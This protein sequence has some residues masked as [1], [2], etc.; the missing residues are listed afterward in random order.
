[1]TE[2][3]F[4]PTAGDRSPAELAELLD[5]RR[6]I[7]TC[8]AS[9]PVEGHSLRDAVWTYVGTERHAGTSP[10]HVI[11]ALTGMIASADIAPASRRQALTRRVIL[12]G[13]EAY[14]GHLDGDVMGRDGD[15]LSDSPATAAWPAVVALS[16]RQ[17]DELP[18]VVPPRADTAARRRLSW[19]PR[20]TAEELANE[21]PPFPTSSDTE[22]EE[23]WHADWRVRLTRNLS[24]R[25]DGRW[26]PLT[27]FHAA[28]VVETV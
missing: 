6:V 3:T 5:L 14:F 22:R 1:M 27:W 21:P 26:E 25:S 16:N 15:A 10:G 11:S 4:G 2:P 9:T 23:S 18:A 7:V 17:I 19:S 8:L 24:R 13:V 20:A 12:W 28:D